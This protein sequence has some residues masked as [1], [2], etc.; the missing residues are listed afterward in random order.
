MRREVAEL[1]RGPGRTLSERYVLSLSRPWLAAGWS[2]ADLAFALNH[3]PGKG[4]HR[5][6]T[7]L[8]RD[9][10][11]WVAWR[12]SRWT[13]HPGDDFAAYKQLGHWSFTNWPEPIASPSAQRAEQAERIR[14]EQAARRADFDAAAAG[15]T[16][17]A[18]FAAAIRARLGWK[19]GVS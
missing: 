16:D 2:A 17:P 9:P 15:R 12:L 14:K 11:H 4:Q 7:A 19:K 3:D 1:Q 18:P 6:R 10:S 5:K 8:V 13:R